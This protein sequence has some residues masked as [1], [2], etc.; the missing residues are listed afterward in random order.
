[1]DNFIRYLLI[2]V[3]LLAVHP[4]NSDELRPASLHI[5]TN[6]A[7]HFSVVWKVPARGTNQK[8]GINVVFDEF[9]RETLPPRTRIV[10]GAYISN[11]RITRPGGLDGAVVR[12]DGLEAT[13]NDVLLRVTGLD[14]TTFTRVLSAGDPEYRFDQQPGLFN[15]ISTYTL[16]GIEHILIGLDHLLFVACLV[17]ISRTRRKLLITISGFTLAH[18]ITLILASM[19]IIQLPIAPVEAIIALSIV[20]LALEIVKDNPV[21]LSMRYPVLVAS[22][23]GLL[24]GFGFASVLG[25]IGLPQG[26]K[27]T[28][29]LFFNVGVE[30]G[31]IIFVTA[32]L[33]FFLLLSLATRLGPIRLKNTVG[34]SAGTLASVW[35][36]SRLMAF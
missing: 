36:I 21:S 18:S 13:Y 10:D 14:G 32:L 11:W 2:L 26:E 3:L 29:L 17:F 9:V 12:I 15:I 6:E 22:S 7:E 27:I 25:E 28:A 4:A 23:F 5:I 1:V 33:V 8:L 16:L 19:D 24:H 30:I 20:F 35:L 31:Q 34:Y